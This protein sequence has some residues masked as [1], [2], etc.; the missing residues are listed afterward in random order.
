MLSLACACSVGVYNPDTDPSASDITFRR[1]R[2]VSSSTFGTTKATG[3]WVAESQNPMVTFEPSLFIAIRGSAS[4]LDH[5]VNLNGRQ[6]YASK[7]GFMV[8]SMLPN[9]FLFNCV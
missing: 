4:S 9:S 3:F 1:V 6:E 5:M 2:Y 8:S 7:D